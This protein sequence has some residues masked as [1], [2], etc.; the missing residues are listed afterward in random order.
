MKTRIMHVVDTL[1]VGG[2]ENGVVN[3]IHRMDARRFEHAVCAVRHV[4]ALADRLPHDRVQIVCLNKTAVGFSLQVRPLLRR[5][6][7]L[8]PDIV[9]SRN[10]GAIDAILAG[11]WARSC[12]LI[13]SEHGA[14]CISPQPDPRRRRWLRWLVFQLADRVV[15]VSEQLRHR[16]ALATGF[17]VNNITVIHNGVDAR[18]F[19]PQPAVRPETRKRLGIAPEEFCIGAVGRLE[20]VKDL[21]TLLR[22]AAELAEPDQPWRLLIAGEG[23][24]LDALRAF[25]NSHPRLKQRVCFLGG[26]QNVPELLNALDVYVLPSLYEGISNSLLEAMATSLPVIASTVGGNPEVVVDNESGLLFSAGDFRALAAQLRLIRDDM[27]LRSRL[28]RRALERVRNCFSLES[29]VQ[30]YE[31]L[32]SN[33][34][35]AG[36]RRRMT[37]QAIKD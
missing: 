10:W 3:L 25:V 18:R 9:H 23:S 2:L 31:S 36:A 27:D 19:S 22:A 34:I 37:N 11:S 26:V 35:R 6:Q 12:A 32:Y 17:P 29:M 14:E 5:I 33:V 21:M 8:K 1:D 28:G 20:P 24:E 13:H 15:C 7:E 4:G 16:H 30:Q